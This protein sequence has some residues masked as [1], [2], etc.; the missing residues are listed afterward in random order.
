[1]KGIW[2]SRH[3]SRMKKSN[4]Y[5]NFETTLSRLLNV[6]HSKVKA[7]LDAE[8]KAKEWKKAKKAKKARKPSAS[9]EVV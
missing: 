8:K 3:G 2:S 4:E 6:P 7:K 1:M 9:R 5:K